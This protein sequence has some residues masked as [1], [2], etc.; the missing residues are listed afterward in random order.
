MELRKHPILVCDGVMTWPPK[1]LQTYGSRNGSVSGEIGTLEAV[2]LSETTVDKVY[3]SIS[4]EGDNF[5]IGTLLFETK[6]PAKAF[7]DLL[8]CQIGRPL[9]AIASLDIPE[10]FGR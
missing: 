1:W 2:Y 7:F 4:M 5:Y 10:S 3:L 6:T 8:R 9:K